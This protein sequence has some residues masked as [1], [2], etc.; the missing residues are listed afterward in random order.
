M[1]ELIVWAYRRQMVQY[2]VEGDDGPGMPQQ[3]ASFLSLIKLGL[4]ETRRSEGWSI[5][6]AGTMAHEDAHEVH[7]RVQA[8]GDP[9]H[10]ALIVGTG[11]AGSPPVWNPKIPP[12]RVV[13]VWKA[14]GSRL[15]MFYAEKGHR[16]LGCMIDY[17]GF[18]EEEAR[19]IRQS[20][21]ESYQLWW[22][23]LRVLR[24]GFIGDS[25]LTR[26]KVTGIGAA[27]EP[28]LAPA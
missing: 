26:W 5:N 14:G 21:I 9:D 2:E 22:R 27:A 7:A 11:A 10:R 8:L 4:F 1:W 24:V 28:W 17:E 16:P 25:S 3:A 13:P 19:S 18:T 20:A 23:L 6:A 15:E 12:L